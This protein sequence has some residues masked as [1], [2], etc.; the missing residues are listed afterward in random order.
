MNPEMQGTAGV[1]ARSPA[2]RRRP[3]PALRMVV[4]LALIGLLG[5]GFVAF[6]NFKAGIIRQVIHTITSQLPT[7][8]TAAAQMS[9]WQTELSATGTL[10][11]SRGADLAPEVAGIVDAIR[12]NSGEDVAAGTLLLRLR[13][14]DDDAKLAQ[15]V[16]AADLADVTYQ[17]DLKQLRVQGV[18]QAVV[19][20]D[21]AN[22]RAARAQ[23][24]A[25]KAVMDE[26][27]VRAPFAGRL[28]IRQV[29]LG[30]FLPAGTTVVTLQALDPIYV[31]FYLPQSALA[32]LAVGAPVSVS[33][34]GYPDRRFA[35]TLSALAAKIDPASRMIQVRATLANPD[36]ALL[37]GMFATATVT[38]GAPE[39]HVTIPLAS[40]SYNPYGAIVYVVHDEGTGTDGKPKRVARQQFVTTGATRGDQVA[41]LK[42][43]AAGNVV[44]TAGQLKL[45]NNEAVLVDNAVQPTDE[46][47]PSP[48]DE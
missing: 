42:G 19:D 26:K 47:N 32:S 9:P 34:D 4:M 39:Q 24:D 38:V 3:R 20:S 45:R 25:Q 33:V 5:A 13:P 2:H 12:F 29:D 10:R 15:L 43:L 31:D 8:S 46:A 48:P 36:K 14:N 6:Q 40:V 28:G 16:A 27:L 30:Q 37:P 41:I 21:A 17:R 44:V 11:A 22:L 18:A 23:V 7:V 1:V 35:G